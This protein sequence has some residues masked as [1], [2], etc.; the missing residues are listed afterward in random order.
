MDKF[1]RAESRGANLNVAD[2]AKVAGVAIEEAERQVREFMARAEAD[3]QEIWVNDTYQV[4]KRNRGEMYWLSIKR[5]DK[6][7]I[8]DW[9]HLQQIKNELVGP[10]N[11]GIELYPAESRLVDS[12]NQYHLWVFA[13]PSVRIDVGF[14]ERLVTDIEVRGTK[15]RKFDG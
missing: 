5:L 7:P 8:H 1:V 14:N 2:L 12:S 4:I 15:Q 11:E 10:D 13:D 3:Q 6:E 9:R